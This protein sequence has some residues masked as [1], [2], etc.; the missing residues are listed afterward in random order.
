MLWPSVPIF[1][2]GKGGTLSVSRQTNKAVSYGVVA[3]AESEVGAAGGL[4]AS[5][6]PA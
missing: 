6:L 4:I 5:V 1:T 3:G 2:N